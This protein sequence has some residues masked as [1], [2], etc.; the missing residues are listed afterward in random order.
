VD[1]VSF[2]LVNFPS[3]M[4]SAIRLDNS[5]SR[6]WFLGRIALATPKL[7]CTIDEIAE[8]KDLR[9]QAERE[10][11]WVLSHV[12]EIVPSSPLAP[13]S[14]SALMGDIHLFLGL[15]RGAWCGPLFPEGYKGQSL[16]WEPLATWH[17]EDPNAVDTWLPER[18]PL[19]LS[20]LFE[21]FLRSR[22]SG[23]WSEPLKLA[24]SWYVAANS[25]YVPNEVRIVLAQLAL[26]LLAHV[27]LV[28]V[29]SAFPH[30]AFQDLRAARRVQELLRHLRIPE[31]VPSYLSDLDALARSHGSDGPAILVFLRNRLVH[32][33]ERSRR[34]LA[35]VD[36]V[37]Y[38]EAAHL[39][40]SY[41][42]LCLLALL[43]YQGKYSRRG[44]HGWKGAD[45]ADVPWV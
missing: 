25:S 12:A 22:E 36:G 10:G 41:V 17:V 34:D 19:S 32:A 2:Y 7:T 8:A 38:L 9:Q 23:A 30:Q 4:G 5:S 3:Y 40:L 28:E 13:E 27:E 35:A 31:A 18:S 14:L 29:R 26:D 11:G 6:G 44:W 21:N 37:H 15:L 42:E 24:V 43:G 39:A 16:V 45:E 20:V 33:T 1:R